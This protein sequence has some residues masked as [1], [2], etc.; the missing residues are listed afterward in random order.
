MIENISSLLFYPFEKQQ[1]PYPDRCSKTLFWNAQYVSAIENFKNFDCLQSF[2]PYAEIWE[3]HNKK[4]WTELAPNIAYKNIFCILPQQKDAALYMIASSFRALEEDGLLLCVAANN[5]G[6]KNIEKWMKELGTDPSSLSKS[7]CRIVWAHNN[8]INQEKIDLYIKKAS[9]QKIDMNGQEFTTQPGIF[10]WDKIDKGSQLLL[11]NLPSDLKGIGADFGCGYGYLSFEI[12]KNNPKIKKLYALEAN[13]DALSC[14][15]ENLRQYEGDV[16]IEYGWVDLK[17]PQ[18]GIESLDWIVM[19][20]PFHEGKKTDENAGLAFI[21]Q[22]VK[23]LKKEGVLYMVA[24]A[25][26]PY[27]KTLEKLFSS[28]TKTCEEQGYKIFIARK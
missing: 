22:A 2:K 8:N 28:V 1:I 24:N 23:V 10:G 12:L 13:H 4:V 15:Q 11:E 9:Q 17:Q 27:E 26:L 19:N 5:A 7:K 16:D 14:A 6:G 20:P 3:A 21:T 18:E 25:H